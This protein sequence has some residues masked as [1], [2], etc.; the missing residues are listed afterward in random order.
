MHFLL[1]NVFLLRGLN[2]PSQVHLVNRNIGIVS[3]TT[4]IYSLRGRVGHYT[5]I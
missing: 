3:A 2:F 5:V 1:H 4:W